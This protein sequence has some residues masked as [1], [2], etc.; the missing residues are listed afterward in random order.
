MRNWCS[1]KCVSDYCCE[2]QRKS[3]HWQNYYTIRLHSD[4]RQRSNWISFPWPWIKRVRNWRPRRPNAFAAVSLSHRQLLICFKQL[5][6]AG[7]NQSPSPRLRVS[8]S[9]PWIFLSFALGASGKEKERNLFLSP[10][11]LNYQ[12]IGSKAK[13]HS[14]LVRFLL[15]LI[16]IRIYQFLFSALAF[17]SLC[18]SACMN[19]WMNPEKIQRDGTVPFLIRALPS[20]CLF[21]WHCPCLHLLLLVPP[22]L[23]C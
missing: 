7:K 6:I 9:R 19:E 13:L 3:G 5:C 20:V 8:S 17:W 10:R 12:P 21:L 16:L 4:L 23:M 11:K 18:I 14:I 2:K 15:E 1:D 22:A